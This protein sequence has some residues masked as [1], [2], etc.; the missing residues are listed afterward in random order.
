MN[1][2]FY[3]HCKKELYGKNVNIYRKEKSKKEYFKYSNGMHDVKNYKIIKL[4]KSNIKFKGGMTVK[5]RKY[6]EN[7]LIVFKKNYPLLYDI[8]INNKFVDDKSNSNSNS[9]S[10]KLNDTYIEYCNF[11]YDEDFTRKIQDKLDE[12][13]KNLISSRIYINDCIICFNK[14]AEYAPI[15]CCQKI[16]CEDCIKIQPI[17]CKYSRSSVINDEGNF[18]IFDESTNI[19]TYRSYIE[20]D[21]IEIL[22]IIPKNKREIFRMLKKHYIDIHRKL[23]KSE[24]INNNIDEFKYF[25]NIGKPKDHKDYLYYSNILRDLRER[26]ENLVIEKED[27]LICS[28][29][30]ATHTFKCGHKCMCEDCAIKLVKKAY[31]DE[32]EFVNCILCKQENKINY[33]TSYEIYD[34]LYEIYD[35]SFNTDKKNVDMLKIIMNDP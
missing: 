19:Q 12:I 21:K 9:I 4:D 16:F 32:E 26:T 13:R 25:L 8:Y 10:N 27:C 28:E 20:D 7:F 34:I 30:K 22:K 6:E 2:I 3:F 18:K 1:N 5:D 35:I 29:K 11:I 15:R 14:K 17:L 31:V 24:N 33:D 23:F